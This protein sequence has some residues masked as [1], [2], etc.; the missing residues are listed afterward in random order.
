MINR[1]LAIAALVAVAPANALAQQN[2]PRPVEVQ[3]L[4]ELDAW[5]VSALSRAEG[6]LSADLWTRSDPNLLATAFERLPT[7]YQSP[8]AQALARRVLFS[9]GDAPRGDAITAARMRFDALARMGAADQLATMAAGSNSSLSDPVIAQFAAQAELARGRRSEACARGRGANFGDPPPALLLRLRAYCAAAAGD[10]AAADLALSLAR[11]N[12]AEDAWFAG[13]VA[14]AGGAAP[15]RP[16]AARYENALTTQL[17]LAGNLRPGANPLADVSTLSLVA[18]ARSEATQQPVRAQAT[19]LAYRRGALTAAETR[20][21]LRA[22]PATI[23]T[24]LPVIAGALRQ[25]DAAPGSIEAATAIATV[26][27]QAGV[28]AEFEAAARFF[29][30]DI[31]ALQ[32]APDHAAALMFARASLITG[33]VAVSQRLVASAR[34][35]GVDEAAL[36]PLDLALAVLSNSVDATVVQRRID[37]GASQPRSAARDLAILAGLGVQLEG[38]AQSALLRN[39]PQGGVQ[40][41]AGALV[42]LA[43]AV[44]RRAVGEGALLAIVASS[45]AGPARLDAESLERIIRSL[46]ALGL[47]ADAR[48]IAVEAIL[49]GQPS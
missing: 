2:L 41:D 24:G 30:A 7:I 47:E 10:R 45:E 23:T 16:P 36:A 22:T 11:T 35:A 21:I 13:A 31:A 34:A 3:S 40:G 12:A 33:D 49:A 27:R 39:T 9:G 18:L 38:A 20:T 4:R 1:S 8:S 26:L 44:E 28:A 29:Q 32:T 17:S 48:R 14:A 37:R 19:A 6:A 46:R 42:A 15:A 5:S 43:G 25:V